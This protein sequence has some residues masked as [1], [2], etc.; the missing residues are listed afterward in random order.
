MIFETFLQN[1][2]FTKSNLQKNTM[3]LQKFFKKIP[4]FT[5]LIKLAKKNTQLVINILVIGVEVMNMM[6]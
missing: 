6:E 2:L 5:Y 4:P 3:V 1:H